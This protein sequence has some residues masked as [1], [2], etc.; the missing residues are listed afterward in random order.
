MKDVKER[1]SSQ[2]VDRK[3]REREREER[4]SSRRSWT[5]AEHKDGKW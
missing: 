5:R 1:K 3:E 2:V 4:R